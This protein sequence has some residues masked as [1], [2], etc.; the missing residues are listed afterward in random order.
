MRPA[1]IQY[2]AGFPLNMKAEASMASAKTSD[3]RIRFLWWG[4][5]YGVYITF[6]TVSG[7]IKCGAN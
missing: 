4:F 5:I 2:K 7:Q 3:Q 6:P 1:S